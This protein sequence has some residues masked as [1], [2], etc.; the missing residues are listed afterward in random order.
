MEI[1]VNIEAV[2]SSD[3]TG[4]S[5]D[6]PEKAKA[7]IVKGIEKAIKKANAAMDP[8]QIRKGKA[9]KFTTNPKAAQKGAFTLRIKVASVSVSPGKTS[10]KL[11]GELNRFPN[12][13]MI[14][15]SMGGNGAYEGK[16]SPEGTLEAIEAIAEDMARG[17]ALPVMQTKI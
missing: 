7:A 12:G 10:V 1:Y 9:F 17:K 13:E 15:T 14:S 8:E 6:F 5:A 16:H 11:S 3:I 4:M 2:Y